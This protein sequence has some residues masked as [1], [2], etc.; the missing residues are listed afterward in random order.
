MKIIVF[1][2]ETTG[3]PKKKGVPVFIPDNWGRVVQLAYQVYNEQGDLLHEAERIVYPEGYTIP[4][5]VAEI[6]RVTTERAIKEG[7]PIEEVL[8]GFAEYLKEPSILVAHN[9]MFDIQTV[10][11]EFVRA[12]YPIIPL[13]NHIRRDTMTATTNLCRL[14]KKG[15]YRGYKSPKLS[16]LYEFLFEKELK[17]AHDALIDVQAC[18]DCYFELDDNKKNYR[19][20]W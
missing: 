20:K 14:P 4:D 10:G 11:A 16:E 17:D 1:D 7:I 18:A 9:I 12:G 6:H 2:C 5:E 8:S 13:Y 3:L 19:I 15:N